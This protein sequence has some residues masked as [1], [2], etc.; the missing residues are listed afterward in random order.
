MDGKLARPGRKVWIKLH[1]GHNSIKQQ[2]EFQRAQGQGKVKREM[3]IALLTQPLTHWTLD[4]RGR[5]IVQLTDT[6]HPGIK[7]KCDECADNN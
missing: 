3:Q 7:Q 1:N 6:V 4:G 5:T 2:A